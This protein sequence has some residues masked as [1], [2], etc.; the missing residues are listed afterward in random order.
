[1]SNKLISISYTLYGKD[2][3]YYL[4]LIKQY[5]LLNSKVDVLS[6]FDFE[7]VVFVDNTVDMEYFENIPIKFIFNSSKKILHNVPP[8]MWRFYNVFL[9]SADVF[10]FRDSDSLISNRELGLIKI[11]LE[12]P[13]NANVI[14]DT[15]L[16]LY[17][18]MAGTFSIRNDCVQELRNI[19][20]QHRCVSLGRKHFYDQI[21]LT[22]FVYQNILSRLLVFS[23]FLVFKN[24]NY[25]RTDYRVADFIGGYYH[26][27]KIERHWHD[28]HFV[29]NFS[30]KVL[31]VFN[32][33]TRL[34]IIYISGLIIIRNLAIWF[35]K[36]IRVN[37]FLLTYIN[38]LAKL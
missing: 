9:T 5:E 14:R 23:N 8:K 33:S 30:T 24:E 1:M 11:W 13:Y 7:M 34:N 27:N 22:E 35:N 28:F 38:F 10:L 21:Y 36:F 25:I 3:N 18:I 12:S 26:Y 2:Y 37:C 6:G 20:I 32:Y 17:P 19:L 31:K 29:N 4:P 15:R 16:H